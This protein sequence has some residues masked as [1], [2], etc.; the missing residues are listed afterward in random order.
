MPQMLE[1]RS[2]SLASDSAMQRANAIVDASDLVLKLRLIDQVSAHLMLAADPEGPQ[3]VKALDAELKDLLIRLGQDAAPTVRAWARY[4]M[5]QTG[6]APV[7]KAAT[8][9]AAE[10]VWYSRLLGAAM[11][12]DA[13]DSARSKLLE[14]AGNDPDAT[15]RRTA[16]AIP[17][18]LAAQAE[19]KRQ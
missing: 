7:E 8:D 6:V 9:L 10:Q 19:S 15:V 4:R 14:A 11:T 18:A 13:P 2:A 3:A 16:L 17:V 12:I 5:G 1:R